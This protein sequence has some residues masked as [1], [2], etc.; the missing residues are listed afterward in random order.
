MVECVFVEVFDGRQPQQ[1]RLVLRDVF[2]DRLH[3]PPG[4]RQGGE[5]PA[6]EFVEHLLKMGDAHEK[7]LDGVF[8]FYAS[9]AE[10]QGR[11]QEDVTVQAQPHKL[12][13]DDVEGNVLG[14][15]PDQ[16]KEKQLERFAGQSR[17]KRENADSPFFQALDHE[18]QHFIGIDGKSD[19][20]AVKKE[21][22]LSEEETG[23]LLAEKDAPGQ[24]I[25]NRDLALGDE[26]FRFVNL[27]DF[28]GSSQAFDIEQG[29]L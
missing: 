8:L 18:F 5:L 4:E 25:E 29:L 12:R 20:V 22:V 23:L 21:G 6:H 2:E 7:K 17:K 10:E 16:E 11:P 14:G 27:E 9:D 28:Q 1:K 3:H 15:S 24:V 13:S 19:L 26:G